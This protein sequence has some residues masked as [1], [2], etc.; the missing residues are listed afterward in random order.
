MVL[1]VAMS[2]SA[3]QYEIGAMEA[4]GFAAKMEGRVE[5]REIMM[6]LEL[7]TKKG[8]TK[9]DFDIVNERNGLTYVSDGTETFTVQI[10]ERDGKKKGYKFNH[11]MTFFHPNGQFVLYYLKKL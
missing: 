2:M 5:F 8:T 7:E 3:Q 10:L 1:L 6:F 4:M 9:A 11:T